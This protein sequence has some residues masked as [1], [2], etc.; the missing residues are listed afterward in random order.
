VGGVL[1]GAGDGE[2][3]LAVTVPALVICLLKVVVLLPEAIV[4]AVVEPPVPV[5]TRLPVTPE[6]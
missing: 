3:M 2:L 6:V 4:K 1:L 5:S